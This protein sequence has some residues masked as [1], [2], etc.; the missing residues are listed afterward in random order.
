MKVFSLNSA[1]DLNKFVK[2]YALISLV[3]S[4]KNTPGNPLKKSKTLK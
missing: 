2:N 3:E 1:E 4:A